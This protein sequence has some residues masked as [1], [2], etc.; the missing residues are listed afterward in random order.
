MGSI[1]SYHQPT[2]LANSHN[3]LPA[4]LCEDDKSSVTLDT[5]RVDPYRIYGL[6]CVPSN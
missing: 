5:T 6:V 4:I 1:W 2:N 3:I